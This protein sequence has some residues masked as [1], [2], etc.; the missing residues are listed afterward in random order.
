M[1]V[2]TRTPHA[3]VVDRLRAARLEYGRV[4]PTDERGWTF[5]EVDTEV[6]TDDGSAVDRDPD[7]PGSVAEALARVD[8]LV[9]APWVVQLDGGSDPLP[10][11]VSAVLAARTDPVAPPAVVTWAPVDASATSTDHAM[12]LDGDPGDVLAA[13]DALVGLR[14]A[15]TAPDRLRELEHPD[16]LLDV[17]T[18][19]ADLPAT[20][21]AAPDAVVQLVRA[22]AAFVRAAVRRAG[23]AWVRA[24][25]ERT[26]VWTLERP[27]A[28]VP[29]EPDDDVREAFTAALGGEF[30]ARSTIERGLRAGEAMLSLE[31][32]GTGVSWTLTTRG[33]PWV[34]GSWN[35]TWTDL[36]TS[37]TE[38]AFDALVEVFGEPRDPGRLRA[39][40]A[41]STW[42]GDPVAD[43]AYLLGLPSALVEAVEDPARFRHGSE[44]VQPLGPTAPLTPQEKGALAARAP[45]RSAGKTARDVVLVVLGLGLLGLGAAILA[46]DGAVV[47]S[48]GSRGWD[49]AVWIAGGVLALVGWA[50]LGSARSDRR[51]FLSDA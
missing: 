42:S 17:F 12:R 36:S 9:A 50:G 20:D 34:F 28:P 10:P 3:Q 21:S 29:G 4:G 49:V 16:D 30:R 7:V 39:L 18:A 48:D 6:E 44:R 14:D 32:A 51:R 24:T 8:E 1:N 25:D 5:A 19:L 31:R 41:A 38:G 47:G 15:A 23:S 11:G 37:G 26:A 33:R 27:P 22:D 46:T 13:V 35:D 40:L 43:L 45:R 2:V